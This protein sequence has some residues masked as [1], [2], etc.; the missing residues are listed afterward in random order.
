MACHILLKT[1]DLLL[2]AKAVP[3]FNGFHE[4]QEERSRACSDHH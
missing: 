1:K 4:T 2:T 3:L